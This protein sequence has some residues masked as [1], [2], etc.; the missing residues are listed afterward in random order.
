M[1]AGLTI[2]E[3]YGKY[4]VFNTFISFSLKLERVFQ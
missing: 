2:K 1:D 4:I 3:Q